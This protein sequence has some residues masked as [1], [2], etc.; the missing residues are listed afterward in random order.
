[1]RLV[2]LL[3]LLL[4]CSRL[5]VASRSIFPDHTPPDRVILIAEL[6]F[7]CKNCVSFPMPTRLLGYCPVSAMAVR[8]HRYWTAAVRRRTVFVWQECF[9]WQKKVSIAVQWSC[10]HLRDK[11]LFLLLQLLLLDMLVVIL[12][13]GSMTI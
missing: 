12:L 10:V 6:D 1:M 7:A 3:S 11:V 8:L 2:M 4:R 13:V 5:P 9:V